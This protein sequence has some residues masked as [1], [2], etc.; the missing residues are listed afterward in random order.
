MK[1]WRHWREIEWPALRG[2]SRDRKIYRLDARAMPTGPRLDFLIDG[3]RPDT[4]HGMRVIPPFHEL[5]YEE[6]RGMPSEAYSWV[7]PLNREDE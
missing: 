4:N 1:C 6:I 5:S 3:L 7:A 2:A